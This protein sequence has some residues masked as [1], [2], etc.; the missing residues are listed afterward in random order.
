M[1]YLSSGRRGEDAS[2]ASRGRAAR[3]DVVPRVAV[4]GQ[5]GAKKRQAVIVA[6]PSANVFGVSQATEPFVMCRVATLH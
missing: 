3:A 2:G 4:G 6:A 5:R 1:R